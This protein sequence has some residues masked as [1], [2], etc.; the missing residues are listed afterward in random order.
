M[1][2]SR[3]AVPARQAARG[4]LQTA[5]AN[6]RPLVSLSQHQ[7]QPLAQRRYATA[8]PS[9]RRKAL[10]RPVPSLEGRLLFKPSDIPPIDIWA[11][12][13]SSQG[14]GDLTAEDALKTVIN[15]CDVATQDTSSWKAA[16]ERGMVDTQNT[17]PV[18]LLKPR[19]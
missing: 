7:S 13:K 17:Q 14:L 3:T 1:L 12:Y 19:G 8:A 5:A 2:P 9:V 6:A 15:Y 11:E 18:R 10:A 16:L 4:V